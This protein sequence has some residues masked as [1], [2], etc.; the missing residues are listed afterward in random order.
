M[1]FMEEPAHLKLRIGAPVPG[2]GPSSPPERTPPEVPAARPK[3]AESAQ[4]SISSDMRLIDEE[5][6]KGEKVVFHTGMHWMALIAPLFLALFALVFFWL[7]FL[8]S[9]VEG[10]GGP[11][12]ISFCFGCLFALPL[13]IGILNL[14]NTNV[15]VTNRRILCK[16]GIV[17]KRSIELLLEKIEGIQVVRGLLGQFLDYGTIR[18]AGAGLGNAETFHRIKAPLAIRKHVNEQIELVAQQKA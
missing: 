8:V 16:T 13:S 4:N 9:L 1:V 5:L 15:A 3:P 12:F 10:R 7:P 14:V 17:R 2:P 11:A 6:L 18:I